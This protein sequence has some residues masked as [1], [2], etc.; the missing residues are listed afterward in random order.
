MYSATEFKP[1]PAVCRSKPSAW[2]AEFLVLAGNPLGVVTS[3]SFGA[4]LQ[5]QQMMNFLGTPSSSTFS[6]DPRTSFSTVL[7]SFC[8]FSACWGLSNAQ[9]TGSWRSRSPFP[10]PPWYQPHWTHCSVYSFSTCFTLC[11]RVCTG[12]F[13]LELNLTILSFLIS[14]LPSN[15]C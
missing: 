14:H 10:T 15:V 9:L 2:Y 11:W 4:A 5:H 12:L 3:F 13:P 7:V 8:M 6:F 1:E